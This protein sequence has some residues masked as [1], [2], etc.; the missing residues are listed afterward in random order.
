ML[1]V[2]FSATTYFWW[3]VKFCAKVV[4]ATLSKGSLVN[5]NDYINNHIMIFITLE[6]GTRTTCNTPSTVNT[7]AFTVIIFSCRQVEHWRGRVHHRPAPATLS[8]PSL[9][10]WIFMRNCQCCSNSYPP[11]R[12][13]R[14]SRGVAVFPDHVCPDEWYPVYTIQ[15]VVKPVVNPVANRLNEQPLFVQPVVKPGCTTGL[16]T[17]LT[18]G[19]I[20]D[21]AGCQIGCQTGLTTG[22]TTGCIV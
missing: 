16:T 5:M 18:T 15:P 20:H 4:G 7:H 19:C 8:R 9:P 11:A 1:K 6:A 14:R 13:L 17:G 21:T 10:K 12:G 2:P 22:L 3:F